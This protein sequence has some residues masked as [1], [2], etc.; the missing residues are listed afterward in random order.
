MHPLGLLV[1]LV[2]AITLHFVAWK[3]LSAR[4]PRR[5]VDPRLTFMGLPRELRDKV[6]DLLVDTKPTP[7]PPAH[8]IIPWSARLPVPLKRWVPSFLAPKPRRKKSV[9][10]AWLNNLTLVS[11]QFG[12]EFKDALYRRS[13]FEFVIDAS[14]PRHPLT[15]NPSMLCHVR[16][17]AVYMRAS[18][19]LVGAFDPRTVTK[20]WLLQKR[21]FKAMEQMTDLKVMNLEIQ[22]QGNEMWNPLWLW[23]YTS[24]AFKKNHVRQ[25]DRIH[26]SL[27][28]GT[29][30][31]P[32][33]LKRNAEG[34]WEWQCPK[35]H[36]VMDDIQGFEAVHSFC[37]HIYQV[38]TICEP[39]TVVEEQAQEEEGEDAVD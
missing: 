18:S 27:Q 20:E 22:A 38:C 30:R 19:Q 12:T 1:T 11:R 28:S 35:G 34:R 26:F 21:V 8:S 33:H 7:Q 6:F 31:E 24:Q 17:A 25:F 29:Y 4:L 14:S 36:W 39:P 10:R 16:Y 3:L 32:N 2:L 9:V 23:Y 5:R 37:G 15:D 13:T